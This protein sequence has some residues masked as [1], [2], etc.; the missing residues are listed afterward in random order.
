MSENKVFPDKE[1]LSLLKRMMKHAP[2][3]EIRQNLIEQIK[4]LEKKIAEN[5]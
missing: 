1:R 3:D 4:E 2:N 5:E